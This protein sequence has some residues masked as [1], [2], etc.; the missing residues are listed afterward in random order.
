MVVLSMED[1]AKV[2]ELIEDAGLARIMPKAKRK[3]ASAPN[4]SHEQVMR[5]LGMKPP[6]RRRAPRFG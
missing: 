6:L 2:Q 1:F 3:E 5:R 4:I